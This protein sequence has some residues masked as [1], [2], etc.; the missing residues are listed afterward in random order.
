[1]SLGKVHRQDILEAVLM[2]RELGDTTVNGIRNARAEDIQVKVTL[3]DIDEL[4]EEGFLTRDG[5]EIALTAA[6]LKIAN[7]TVRR[8]RLT[9]MLL[10]TLLG[11]DRSLASEIGCRVEHTVREEMLEGVCTLLGHPSTCPHGRPIPPGKCCQARRSTVVCPIVPLTS[12]RPGERA[13]IV[14]IQPR[15]HERLHRLAA[16]GLI[17]GVE[18]D[19]HRRR[20][21][22]CL[23]FEGTDVALDRDVAQDIQ[24][25]RIAS[26]P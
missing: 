20:P 17:P 9:E 6:G 24:V 5:D 13:R 4:V 22:F 7:R 21:A 18:V 15:N 3:K 19:L 12:L 8:H 14:Y 2:A 23:R 25:S 10:F 11:I 1:M 26:S 16:L